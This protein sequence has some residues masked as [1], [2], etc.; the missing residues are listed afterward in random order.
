M[1]AIPVLDAFRFKR[2]WTDYSETGNPQD[3]V[4][5]LTIA[6][7]ADWLAGQGL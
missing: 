6:L 5:L 3:G 4:H 7:L 1:K 2:L